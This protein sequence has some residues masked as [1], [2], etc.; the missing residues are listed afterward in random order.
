[1][2]L[3]CCVCL[4]AYHVH[5]RST[6]HNQKIAEA[7]KQKALAKKQ[8]AAGTSA[9]A[10]SKPSPSAAPDHPGSAAGSSGD[11]G[12]RSILRSAQDQSSAMG[13]SVEKPARG[14]NYCDVCCFEFSSAEV[15]SLPLNMAEMLMM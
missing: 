6:S 12:P 9:S 10:Q 1:M 7:K 11:A 13:S 15:Y 2:A 5:I 14:P 3:I 4:K 8:S